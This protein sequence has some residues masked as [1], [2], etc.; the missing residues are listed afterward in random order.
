MTV[1]LYVYGPLAHMCRIVVEAI[2][3]KGRTRDRNTTKMQEEEEAGQ[4]GAECQWRK[5]KLPERRGCRTAR[6]YRRFPET[7]SRCH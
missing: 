3:S 2:E 1:K 4:I 5:L 7:M 6:R